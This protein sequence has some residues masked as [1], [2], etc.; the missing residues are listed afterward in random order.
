MGS[1]LDLSPLLT[2]QQIRYIAADRRMRAADEN[3][4]MGYRPKGIWRV[5]R[6]FHDQTHTS[7]N[8]FL[9]LV[10]LFTF[11]D[12]IPTTTRGTRHFHGKVEGRWGYHWAAWRGSPT[13]GGA[14][15]I[16]WQSLEDARGLVG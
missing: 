3:H 2:L 6:S 1:E 13:R 9:V 16:R 15:A 11:P 12:R 10:D 8:S 5:R 4:W 7:N 14:P